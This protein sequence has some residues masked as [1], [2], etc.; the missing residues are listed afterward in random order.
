MRRDP[1]DLHD[2][3]Q[4]IASTENTLAKLQMRI[5]RLHSEGSDASQAKA[6]LALMQSNLGQLYLRQTHLRRGSWAMNR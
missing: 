5:E 1:A 6:H 2:V 3:A 4:R